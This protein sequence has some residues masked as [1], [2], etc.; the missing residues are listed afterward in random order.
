VNVN[1]VQPLTVGALMLLVLLSVGIADT[2]LYQ[3][4]SPPASG[5]VGLPSWSLVGF[6]LLVGVAAACILLW[7]P[8][9]KLALA[10]PYV[11][12][13]VTTTGVTTY[14]ALDNLGPQPCYQ[15]NAVG[16]G[17]L[18]SFDELNGSEDGPEWINIL[19]SG[20]EDP[21]SQDRVPIAKA[22]DSSSVKFAQLLSSLPTSL[23]A[24][25]T[26]LR[27]VAGSLSNTDGQ[28]VTPVV[29]EDVGQLNRYAGKVCQDSG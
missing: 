17:T 24:S 11:F 13:L 22:V 3:R 20:V 27:D 29:V 6:T 14:R 10:I 18:K 25:V 28:E 8:S 21:V 23:R 5:I 26:K 9:N 16:V 19:T 2:L 15:L 7:A 4:T 12:L 1:R